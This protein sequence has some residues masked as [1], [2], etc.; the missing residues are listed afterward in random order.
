MFM[1]ESR[2]AAEHEARSQVE[3]KE[4][5]SAAGRKA[6]TG[7]LTRSERR[8]QMR[9]DARVHERETFSRTRETHAAACETLSTSCSLSFFGV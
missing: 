6:L 2:C 5:R 8:I 3:V 7:G 9:G 4:K 1:S